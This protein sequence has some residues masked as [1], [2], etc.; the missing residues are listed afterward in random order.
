MTPR[1]NCRHNYEQV[2]SHLPFYDLFLRSIITLSSFWSFKWPLPK[3]FTHHSSTC[4]LRVLFHFTPP[5]ELTESWATFTSSRTSWLSLHLFPYTYL[6]T[7][8]ER[9]T[10]YLPTTSQTL[11]QCGVLRCTISRP[12]FS[13][14][15]RD[16]DRL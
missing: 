13:E 5:A 3:T 4:I 11:N 15:K 10:V 16:Y 8:A 1:Y 12:F 6:A 2:P 14:G 7:L 9:G